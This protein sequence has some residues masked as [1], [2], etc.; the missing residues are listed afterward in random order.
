MTTD[1]MLTQMSQQPGFIAALD[2]SGGSTPGA[3]R[4]YGIPDSAYSGDAEMFRLMHEMRVRIMTAPAF[5]GA[6]IIGAILFEGTMDGQVHGKPVPTYLWQDR[7]VV[8]FVKVDQGLEPEQDGVRLMRPMPSL[9]A[10]LARAVKLGVFGTK[11]RSVINLASPRGIDA[12]VRQQFEFAERIAKH[13]LVPIIEPEV[14]VDSPEKSR[15]EAI[16]REALTTHLAAMPEGRRVMLKLTIPETPDFYAPLIGHA[17]VVR[18]VAL[19][20]G[21]SQAKACE[22]LAANHGMIASFSRALT[23]GLVH[24][25]TDSAFDSAL[26]DSIGRIYR[27][28]TVKL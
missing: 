4:L 22:R 6:T 25:M 1:K 16:L 8:P 15:A 21:Y 27:A 23:E 7:G 12:V 9:D 28:S 2:Q 24:K 5:T 18:V 17:R 10:T 19:S 20:G 14:L 11:M 3:L 26:A 13:G